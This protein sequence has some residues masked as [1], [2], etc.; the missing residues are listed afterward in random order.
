MA[1][2]L[3][4]CDPGVDISDDHR[5]DVYGFQCGHAAYQDVGCGPLWGLDSYWAGA[6]D[7]EAEAGVEA[8]DD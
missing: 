8:E 6:K 3:W 1:Q 4:V 7:Q 5:G 2:D